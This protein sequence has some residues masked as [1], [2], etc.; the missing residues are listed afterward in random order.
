MCVCVCLIFVAHKGFGI[1]GMDICENKGYQNCE[2]IRGIHR[3][4]ESYDY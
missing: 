1:W 3:L 4:I 2:L